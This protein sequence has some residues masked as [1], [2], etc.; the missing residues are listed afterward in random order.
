MRNITKYIILPLIFG[1]VLTSGSI[2][3]TTYTTDCKKYQGWN[4]DGA[5]KV[6]VFD[7]YKLQERKKI[8]PEFTVAGNPDELG[9]ERG[10]N[11]ALT[12]KDSWVPLVRDRVISAERC[13]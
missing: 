4:R 11:Y 3:S 5:E 6:L 9:L 2:K 10:K 12:I 8:S 1:T 13:E 7:P